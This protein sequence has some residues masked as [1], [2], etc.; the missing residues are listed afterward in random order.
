MEIISRKDAKFHGLNKYFT[1]IPCK[2]GH[3]VERYTSNYKCPLCHQETRIESDVKYRE[4]HRND[5]LERQNTARTQNPNGRKAESLKYYREHKLRIYTYQRKWCAVNK[6]K[7]KATH[8]KWRSNNPEKLAIANRRYLSIRK[9]AIPMWSEPELI[10]RI[11]LMRDRLNEMWGTSFEVDHIVPLQGKTVCGLHC[12]D[13]LQLL[14]AK[15][16]SSKGNKLK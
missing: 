5:I 9:Q 11:Y 2:R 8:K 3:I 15:L 16:N 7:V 1:G 10:K 13:N 4:I 6:E 12:W 14:E